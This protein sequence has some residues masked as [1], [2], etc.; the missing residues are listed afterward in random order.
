MVCLRKHFMVPVAFK[1]AFTVTLL[2]ISFGVF[3]VRYS[4]L[5]HVYPISSNVV[6]TVIAGDSNTSRGVMASSPSVNNDSSHDSHG[7][8]EHHDGHSQNNKESPMPVA[9]GAVPVTV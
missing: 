2:L 1:E 3:M 9:P 4:A 7:K 6:S 8:H 5:P